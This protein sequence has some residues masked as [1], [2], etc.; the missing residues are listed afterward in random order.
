MS[1]R[2]SSTNL[3]HPTTAF[4]FDGL[5]HFDVPTKALETAWRIFYGRSFFAKKLSK[6]SRTRPRTQRRRA[7]ARKR[8]RR[9]RARPWRRRCVRGRPRKGSTRAA[10]APRATGPDRGGAPR[11]TRNRATAARRREASR[12]PAAGGCSCTTSGS[13][14]RSRSGGTTSASRF[15]A[16]RGGVAAHPTSSSRVRAP[17]SF[18]CARLST[19]DKN[20]AGSFS[21]ASPVA[22]LGPPRATRSRRHPRS[23]PL[24]AE[25][26]IDAKRS[27]D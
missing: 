21:S 26:D 8:A 23:A 10:R 24:Y 19:P 25:R 1:N 9:V 20:A 11:A 14:R 13:S 22:D 17:A 5:V 2:R 6:M 12:C 16:S 3:L 15:L 7:R 4:C 18:K 27:R